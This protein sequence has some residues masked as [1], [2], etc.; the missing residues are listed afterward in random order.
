MGLIT[1]CIWFGAYVGFKVTKELALLGPELT[2]I[3]L[4]CGFPEINPV[5]AAIGLPTVDYIPE[6]NQVDVL[7]ATNDAILHTPDVELETEL[8]DSRVL[9]IAEPETSRV[10]TVVKTRRPKNRRTFA[11]VLAAEA[12]NHFGGMPRNSRANELSVMKYLVGK[13]Q[14]HKLTALQTREVAA[15]AFALTFTPD[16]NDKF[17]YTFLNSEDAYDRRCDYVKSQGVDPMWLRLL[18]R[19]FSRK[20]WKQVVCKFMGFGTREAYTFIK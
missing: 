5:L 9:T 14:D 12:K 16:A 11:C 15:Q 19:P 17:I 2:S 18:K 4:S 3:T 20:E 1:Q 10:T 7:M 13:C 6:V 8:E